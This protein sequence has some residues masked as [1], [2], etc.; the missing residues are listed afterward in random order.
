MG[1]RVAYGGISSKDATQRLHALNQGPRN[2]CDQHIA[3][4]VVLGQN[5]LVRPSAGGQGPSLLSSHQVVGADEMVDEQ[6][7]TSTMHAQPILDLQHRETSEAKL[8]FDG[9]N[10]SMYKEISASLRT[11]AAV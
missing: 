1:E 7:S 8:L 5:W 11:M 6:A 3:P 10:P 4:T 2:L 9:N